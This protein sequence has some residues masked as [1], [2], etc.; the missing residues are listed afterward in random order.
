MCVREVPSGSCKQAFT[1]YSGAYVPN[2]GSCGSSSLAPVVHSKKKLCSDRELSLLFS[3]LG[4][5]K[6]NPNADTLS[7][8]YFAIYVEMLLVSSKV[9]FCTKQRHRQMSP[10]RMNTFHARLT[11]ICDQVLDIQRM[12]ATRNC[13]A[14]KQ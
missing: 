6:L 14:T 3:F 7:T 13:T 10:S 4:T 8:Q 9:S 11:A 2:G 5:P 12:Y 1:T